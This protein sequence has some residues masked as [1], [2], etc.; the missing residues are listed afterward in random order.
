MLGIWKGFYK[1]DNDKIQKI[2]GYDKTEFEIVI[3]KF[4]GENFSGEV[5]DDQS[6]GG[7][8]ETGQIFGRIENRKIYFEKLMP[9]DCQI[10]ENGDRKYSEKNH[11]KIYYSG[12]LSNEKNKF[13]GN[14]KFKRRIG[15]LFFVIPIIYSPGNGTWEMEHKENSY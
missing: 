13:E 14:W 15:L 1:Y 11:P 12:K 3:D 7:M 5:N 8:K 10:S 2:I 9:K 6:T 4:D